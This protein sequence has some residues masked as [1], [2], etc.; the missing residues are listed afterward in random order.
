MVLRLMRRA[1]MTLACVLVLAP[2]ALADQGP[3]FQSKTGKSGQ[4]YVWIVGSC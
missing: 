3:S 4:V 2:A 1:L